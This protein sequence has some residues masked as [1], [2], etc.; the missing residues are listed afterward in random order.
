MPSSIPIVCPYCG[1]GCNLELAL[2]ENGRPF[3]SSASGRN[4]ELNTRYLCVKGF[5]VHELVNHEERLSQP[6]IRKADKLELVSWDEAIRYASQRLKEISGKYGTESIGMLCSGKIL[7]E[8]DYLCQ[9][10]QRAVIGNNHVD[11]CARLCHGPS[12]AAL[13]RQVGYG[14]VSTFL[15]DYEAT[16]TVFLVGAHTTFTHPVIWMQVKKRARKGGLHLILADPRETDLVKNASVHLK[17]KP[18]TDIFWIKAL[19]KIIIDNDWHDRSFCEKQTIGFEAYCRRWR[20]SMSMR[21]A[22]A[23][24]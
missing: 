15:E 19:G 13:R 10:F 24:G 23:L 5:T 16:E 12:E 9:K 18:G 20:I 2:D 17:V 21:P 3:K 4:A 7:N 1:V 6:Y 22:D 8:E 11:N 14:A